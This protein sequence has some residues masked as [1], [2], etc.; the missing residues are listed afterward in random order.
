MVTS[1]MIWANAAFDMSFGRLQL[2]NKPLITVT[3]SDF[4]KAR[5]ILRKYSLAIRRWFGVAPPV[6][7]PLLAGCRRLD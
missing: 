7:K 5:P 3:H 2:P 1:P 4:L 6:L